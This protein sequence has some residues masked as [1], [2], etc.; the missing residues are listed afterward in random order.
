M[1]PALLLAC[2][3]APDDSAGSRDARPAGGPEAF[4]AFE[5]T[6]APTSIHLLASS[7]PARQGLGQA[8]VELDPT[9]VSTWSWEGEGS[10]AQGAWREADGST[11]IART[12]LPPAYASGVD[13]IDADGHLVWS[14]D[15]LF[16][17]GLGFTHGV[18]Q[19]PD[20]LYLT[21]DSTGGDLVAFAEDKDPLWIYPVGTPMDPGIPNG[22]AIGQDADGN[23]VLAITK[24]ARSD[25]IG[26][27]ELILLD[28]PDPEGEPVERWRTTIAVGASRAWAHGPRFQ[29][30]N[31][32]TVCHSLAGRIVA[33]DLDGTELW[34]IPE[35][36]IPRLGFPR[37]ALF[38]EDGSLV[39]SDAALEVLRIADPMGA[40]EVVGAVEVPGVFAVAPITCGAGGGLPCLGN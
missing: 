23:V 36:G 14:R 1:L 37:D 13:K 7:L 17:I 24:L 3:P 22:I 32:L 21:L 27:D 11:V 10:G 34:R 5:D 9:L 19:T 16:S 26:L 12:S 35:E 18:V 2:A 40:F 38:L 29:G 30:P 4:A 31:L 6:V 25:E 28:L 39:V 20:G 33:F 15:D 8:L